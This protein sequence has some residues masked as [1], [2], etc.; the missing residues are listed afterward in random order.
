MSAAAAVTGGWAARPLAAEAFAGLMAPLEPFEPTPTLAVATSGGAD[1][2][3]LAVLLGDWAK[4]RGGRVVALVVDHGLRPASGAEARQVAA[5]LGGLGLEAQVLRWRGAKPEAD[6]QATARAARYRLLTG[7]C[8]RHAVLHL[9]LGHHLDDQAETLL[10]RLGRGS[11][12]DGLA[13][14]APVAELPG[15]R[16]LR[17]LLRV[18]RAALEATLRARG[19]D[20][21]EDPTNRDPAHARVRLRRLAPA[22]EREGLSARRL[23]ATAAHLARARAALEEATAEFLAR[24]ADPDPAGFVWLDPGPWSEAPREVRLRVLARTLMCVGGGAY[25]PR[26]LSLERV[27]SGISSGLARGATLGGCRVLPRRGRLLV[28]RE[29]K[30]APRIAV[31]AGQ[32]LVWDE[33]FEVGLRRTA[34]RDGLTLGPLGEAGWA[35]ALAADPAL[36]TLPLP[37]AVRPSLPSLF[38][39][40]GLLE[41]PMLG[42]LRRPATRWRLAFCRFAPQN[43]LAPVGFTVA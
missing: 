7:W 24:A 36:R 15:L 16:L 2:L 31:R 9:A 4:A 6:I 30:A 10:L 33:R 20:W 29:A 13:G 21:L 35:E 22:L 5:R 3:A 25:T 26:L 27:E 18:P 17:P 1:S 11:G 38:D 39:R 32:R 23:S 40:H 14:M 12:L 37:P 42:F 8:K 28:V 19:L 43:S 41:A 34:G